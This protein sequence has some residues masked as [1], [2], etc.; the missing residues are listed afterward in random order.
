MIILNTNAYF[1]QINLMSL[2]PHK[3]PGP[4][5]LPRSLIAPLLHSI[6][7]GVTLAADLAKTG[8]LWKG[9]IIN[10]N[11]LKGNPSRFITFHGIDANCLLSICF[12]WS[13]Q[14]L[15]HMSSQLLSKPLSEVSEGTTPWKYVFCCCGTSSLQFPILSI[16]SYTIPSHSYSSLF[17]SHLA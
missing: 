14:S 6:Q 9:K 17:E 5:R 8:S 15:F 13:T 7:H 12:G 10:Y 16:L 1:D 2:A 11:I 4:Q 3:P